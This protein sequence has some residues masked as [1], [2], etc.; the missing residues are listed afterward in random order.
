[1][2]KH[3]AGQIQNG[4]SMM[5]VDDDKNI[6]DALSA[7]FEAS[8]YQVDAEN[9]P[10]QALVKMSERHYDILILDYLMRPVCGDV[11]VSRLREFDPRIFVIMLTGHKELA[12]PLESIRSLDIQGYYEK[13]ER[14]DQLELLV[15]SC[16]K[17]IRQMRS[18]DKL[19][20]QLRDSYVQTVESLRLI[21]DAKDIYT[22]GHSDRV[23]CYATRLAVHVNPDPTFI[24]RVR[25]TGLLHDIGKV[26]TSDTILCNPGPLNNLQYAEI[27]RHPGIGA[28]ILAPISMFSEIA[29]IVAAHHERYDGNGYPN[30][31]AGEA[32]PLEARIISIADAF[33]AMMSD[34]H[35]RRHLTLEHAM[36]E[37]ADGRGSQF[38]ATL[39][40]HFL[41]VLEDYP[42]ICKELEWTLD[43]KHLGKRIGG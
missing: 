11:V 32:I 25:I 10:L 27:R 3:R 22:R 30:R 41:Q 15:E 18:I 24:E 16:A 38:D 20:V 35:Y 23:A 9:D 6:T 8:G 4:F 13:S 14:F 21:V 37:L 19:Y 5:I 2:R 42:D 12:P 34:R 1:M 28:S 36:R 33:D 17:S 40:N 26:G 43:A 7:Y 29:P 39:V 31:L